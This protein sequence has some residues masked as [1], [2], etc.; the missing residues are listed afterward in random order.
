M[1]TKNPIQVHLILESLLHDLDNAETRH[2]DDE[3]DEEI[4]YGQFAYHSRGSLLFF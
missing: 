4:D 3:D 2:D 1:D